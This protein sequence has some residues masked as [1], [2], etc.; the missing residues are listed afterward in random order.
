MVFTTVNRTFGRVGWILT[1]RNELPEG[2]P[3]D[4]GMSTT[5]SQ[6]RMGNVLEI[7]PAFCFPFF[8]DL[9][10]DADAVIVLGLGRENICKFAVVATMSCDFVNVASYIS[11]SVL[12]VWATGANEG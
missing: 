1:A 12:I 9:E 7:G 4:G 10:G 3:I 8:F 6:T 2:P 5:R 11:L